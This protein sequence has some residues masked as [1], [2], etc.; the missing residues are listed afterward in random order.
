MAPGG[1]RNRLCKKAIL[2][3]CWRCAVSSSH[4]PKKRSQDKGDKG[5]LGEKPQPNPTTGNPSADRHSPAGHAEETESLQA[6]RSNLIE[7]FAL[8]EHSAAAI[9]AAFAGEPFL[10]DLPPDAPANRRRFNAYLEQHRQVSKLLW[11]ALELWRL[12]FGITIGQS[13]PRPRKRTG[14]GRARKS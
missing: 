8:L 11:R 7:F 6:M 1:D 12:S 3:F 9:D 4:A 13:K 10:P 14:K 5:G 2:I